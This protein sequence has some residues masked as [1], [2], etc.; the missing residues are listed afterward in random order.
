MIKYVITCNCLD[1]FNAALDVLRAKNYTIKFKFKEKFWND[2]ESAHNQWSTITV[3]VA[4]SENKNEESSV[5]AEFVPTLSSTITT[6]SEIESVIPALPVWEPVFKVGDKFFLYGDGSE[7]MLCETE[8][9]CGSMVGLM[10]CSVSDANSEKL[11][12]LAGPPVEVVAVGNITIFD[13]EDMLD[14]TD[15]FD[16]IFEVAPSGEE[17]GLKRIKESLANKLKAERGA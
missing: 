6:T 17:K 7:L 10:Y 5:R 11:G 15:L 13:I 8:F 12:K 4:N 9:E 3:A 14:G 16:K 1:H 2:Y